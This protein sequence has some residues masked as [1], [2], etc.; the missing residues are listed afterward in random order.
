MKN[1][2]YYYYLNGR[3]VKDEDFVRINPDITE[4]YDEN[5]NIIIKL[6]QYSWKEVDTKPAFYLFSFSNGYYYAGSTKNMLNRL[7]Q[8][9]ND[10]NSFSKVD[11]HKKIGDIIRKKQCQLKGN[12]GF[13]YAF[14]CCVKIFI[15]YTSTVEIASIIEKQWLSKIKAE[16]KDIVYYNSIFY[17]N[18]KINSSILTEKI[19]VAAKETFKNRIVLKNINL[20]EPWQLTD[21]DKEILKQIDDKVNKMPE[22][23]DVYISIPKMHFECYYVSPNARDLT[24]WWLQQLLLSNSTTQSETIQSLRRRND[25]AYEIKEINISISGD[26]SYYWFCHNKQYLPQMVENLPCKF[27]TYILKFPNGKFYIGSSNNIKRR[28]REHLYNIYCRTASSTLEQFKRSNLSQWYWDCLN[29][30]GRNKDIKLIEIK[31]KE[32]NDYRQAEQKLMKQYPSNL[33]YN[34]QKRV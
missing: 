26:D 18:E 34:Y 33:L 17:T 24:K 19:E 13:K 10:F 20:E 7:T 25:G 22:N 29:E 27:G 14:C 21:K 16:N 3:Q 6:N 8:H 28:V 15:Q 31:Y 11:W 30:M 4:E 1:N 32:T 2:S 9:Y 23:G 12:K 5:N